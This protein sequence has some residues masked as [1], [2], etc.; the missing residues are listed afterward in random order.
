MTQRY[1]FKD[2]WTGD[3]LYYFFYGPCSIHRQKILVKLKLDNT[4]IST[5]SRCESDVQFD[6]LPIFLLFCEKKFKYQMLVGI[7]NI[8]MVR[9]CV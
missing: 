5:N 8:V 1:K 7:D 4:K 9:S 6:T 3:G 2:R